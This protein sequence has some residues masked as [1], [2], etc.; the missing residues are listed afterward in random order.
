[1]K[2]EELD[3]K[4]LVAMV[5]AASEIAAAKINALGDSINPDHNF[6][7]REFQRVV[8]GVMKEVNKNE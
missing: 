4:I 2:V 1:M 7:D 3:P 5:N 8:E 6:F